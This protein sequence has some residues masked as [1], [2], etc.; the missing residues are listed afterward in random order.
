MDGTHDLGGRQGF[1][2]VPVDTG[3]APF[4]HDWEWRMW[5]LARAGIAH[6]ITIDW[7]RHGLE[8][9]VPADYLSYRLTMYCPAMSQIPMTLRRRNRLTTCWRSTAVAISVSKPRL[10]P[11]LDSQWA[12]VSRQGG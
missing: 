11:S 12:T 10:K 4:S 2:P 6:G 9:M 8:R 7:F 1:G 5:A 3:D